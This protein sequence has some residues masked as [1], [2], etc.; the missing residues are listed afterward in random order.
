MVR[1]MLFSTEICRCGRLKQQT[2]SCKACNAAITRQRAIEAEKRR[3]AR[4]ERN[5]NPFSR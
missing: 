4:L 1:T 2:T 3:E 5:S